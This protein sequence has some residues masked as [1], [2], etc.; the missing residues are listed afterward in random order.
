MTTLNGS[1]ADYRGTSA[2][3]KPT[4]GVAINSLYLELDT[5]TFY[6]FNGEDW[7]VLGGD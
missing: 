2:D 1:N 5:N 3:T 6:Y 7:S 4:E